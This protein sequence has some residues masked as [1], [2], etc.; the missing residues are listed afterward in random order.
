MIDYH[1]ISN[2]IKKYED[3]GYKYIDVPWFTTEKIVNITLPPGK[4]PFH[5]NNDYLVG[6]AE[7]SF[8]HLILAGELKDGKYVA[9][10]PCFRDDEIDQYHQKY[11]FKVEL[12]NYSNSYKFDYFDL[13]NV[14]SDAQRTLSSLCTKTIKSSK[15]NEGV[16]LSINDIEIGSYGIRQFSNF[17][18]IYGTGLAEPRFSS[19]NYG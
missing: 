12:I 2:C 6:S 17:N 7:Q 5:I 8:L 3:L 4:K 18:W 19:L 1:L 9:A 15:T 13:M 14:I 16:D 11:F 10:S